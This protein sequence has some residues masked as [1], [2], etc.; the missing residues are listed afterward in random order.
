MV[1]THEKNERA[2][3]TW[4]ENKG[5]ERGGGTKRGERVW[6]LNIRIHE[7]KGGI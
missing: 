3:E 6:T 7:K 5:L 2:R 1:V 4:R